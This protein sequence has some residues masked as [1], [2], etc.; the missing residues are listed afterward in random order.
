MAPRRK[1]ARASTKSKNVEEEANED[2]VPSSDHSIKSREN[3]EEK[4]EVA[5]KSSE[6]EDEAEDEENSDEEETSSDE[7][8]AVP[9]VLNVTER[10]KRATAGNK[11]AALLA[12]ADQEDEF[13]KTAYGG[14]EENNEIDKEYKSPVHS[15]DDEVDS[16][17]DKEEE[18]DEPVSGEDDE[19]KPR[20]K[21][22]KFNEPK[23]G[24]TADDILAKNKKWAMARLAGNIVAPNTVDEKTQTQ[25]LKE[26]EKTEKLNIESL[27]CYEA[28]ELERKK[29]RE[30]NTVRIFPPGPRVQIK[31]TASGTIMTM[32]EVKKF[33]CERPRERNVCAVTGR[34][35]RYLD[36]LTRLPYSSAYTFKV[37][38]DKYNK[39]LRT[40][41]GNSEVTAYLDQL[42][43]HPTEPMTPPPRVSTVTSS[44][45]PTSKSVVTPP[46]APTTVPTTSSAT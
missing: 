13:Y 1:S 15:D 24:I 3:S 11:M 21:R 10:A 12:S 43:G 8:D 6:K 35:A 19:G 26:A 36:P 30:K 42:K 32:S 34:P 5:S 40:I 4:E 9:V 37:I 17:F 41:R 18:E 7:E 22:K 16:D 28:F 25:M 20:R 23:R 27:K 45:S 46:K 29:K 14:F 38:R 33:E 2:D 31:M 39:H 44:G